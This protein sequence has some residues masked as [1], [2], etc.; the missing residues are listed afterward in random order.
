MNKKRV[1]GISMLLLMVLLLYPLP[2]HAEEKKTEA[3]S[4]SADVTIASPAA[5]LMEPTTGQILFE[6]NA[7][8]PLRPA[9]VTKIMTILLTM[10]AIGEGQASLE[11]LV[12]VS[13]NA[14]GYGGSTILLEAGEQI[15][16]ENLIKG[17]CIASGNDAAIAAAE[18]IGGS[19]EGF[20]ELMN[21]R[22]QELGMRDTHFVN[23]CGL[24]A[25]GHV[26]SA[27]D[28]ALMSGELINRFPQVLEYTGIWHEMMPHNWKNGYGETDMANTNKLIR[29]YEGMKG[30]KTGYTR[31]AGYSLSA[32]A[33]RQNLTLIAVVMGA[34]T[35]EIRSQEICRLLDY[36]FGSYRM[37]QVE[38]DGTPVGDAAIQGGSK[39]RVPAVIKGNVKYLAGQG[40]E[41]DLTAAETQIEWET[42]IEAPLTAG[43]MVGTI[44]YIQGEKLLASLPIVSTE[45][46]GIAVFRDQVRRLL[47]ILL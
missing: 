40:E 17:M 38:T 21:Q 27:H 33:E 47:Q 6:K 42:Q 25:D 16:L 31:L 34:E 1:L 37:M 19:Q 24:D 41:V 26:T 30:L 44:R 12:T 39:E 14:A 5:I 11:D 43:T 4:P 10:E 8:E 32:V 29:S 20:V 15:S 28:I 45:D 23:P 2:V 46:V 13:E 36:G 22:A 18:Y 7:H 3:A 35:K 9:S